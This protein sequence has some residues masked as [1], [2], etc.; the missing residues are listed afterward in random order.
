MSAAV[1]ARRGRLAVLVPAGLGLLLLAC[2]ASLCVGQGELLA[3]WDAVRAVLDGG[4]RDAA[5]VRDA[6]LPRTV[7]A[8]VVGG[9][10]GVAGVLVQALTRNPLASPSTLGL[11]HGAVFAV[12]LAVVTVAPPRG[13]L[14]VAAVLGALVVTAVVVAFGSGAGPA[15]GSRMVLLG[16]A[17]A[18]LFLAGIQFLLVLDERVFEEV[19]RWIVGA[20]TDQTFDALVP[21]TPLFV[22]GGLLAFA[23]AAALDV[24]GSDHD[25]AV[26]LGQRVRRVQAAAAAAVCLLVGGAVA[27][28]GPIVFVGLVVPHAARR[29]VGSEHRAVLPVAL[30]L[31]AI[32][33]VVADTLARRILPTHEVPVGAVTAVLGGPVFVWL[34]R[35]RRGAA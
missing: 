29:L 15:A 24:L 10:L 12:V 17:L 11:V 31:G 19:R 27:L 5:L 34:A 9:A 21:Y 30:V 7:I 13:L 23:T 25:V 16:L 2:V 1:A 22:A 32:L 3:P 20:F 4:H 6:R 18:A 35:G 26:A 33:V 14:G 8:L 28:G